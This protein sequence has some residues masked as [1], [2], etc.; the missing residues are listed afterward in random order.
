[1]TATAPTGITDMRTVGVPVT[2]QDRALAFYTDTLGFEKRLDVAMGGGARWI[3]VAPPGAATSIALVSAHDGVPA[4]VET[5]IR[6]ITGDADAD[7]AALASRGV[8]TGEVLRWE[9]VPPMFAFRDPDG[10]GLEIVEQP[11]TR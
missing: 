1:M 9:G 6:F 4:G 2:D 10:N 3:E 7:H 8:D 5:G 11:S